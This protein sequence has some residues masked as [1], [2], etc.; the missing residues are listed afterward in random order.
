MNQRNR[1][2]YLSAGATNSKT[3][4]MTLFSFLQF[5]GLSMVVTEYYYREKPE[6]RFHLISL[7]EK[8]IL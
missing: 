7:F 5:S 2:K 8:D 6:N 1:V 3:K 4:A